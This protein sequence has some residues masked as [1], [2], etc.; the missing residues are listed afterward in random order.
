MLHH[1]QGA[2]NTEPSTRTSKWRC[3]VDFTV[4]RAF[5]QRQQFLTHTIPHQM[6]AI[7]VVAQ[8]PLSSGSLPCRVVP[9]MSCSLLVVGPSSRLLQRRRL[10]GKCQTQQQNAPRQGGRTVKVLDAKRTLVLL[11][12][13]VSLKAF[14]EGGYVEAKVQRVCVCVCVCCACVYACIRVCVCV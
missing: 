1:H 13:L 6:T 14:C 12:G 2:A 11:K 5:R 3:A 10:L 4:R 7:V 8:L 9:F